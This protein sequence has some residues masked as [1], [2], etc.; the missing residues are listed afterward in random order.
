MSKPNDTEH[1]AEIIAALRD[2]AD[3]IESDPTIPTP[4]PGSIHVWS[5]LMRSEG[6]QSER[7]AA[8]HTFAEAHGA[9]VRIT[10]KDDRQAA[11]H[12]G[13]IELT[14]HAFGDE[15]PA[16]QPRVVTRADDAALITA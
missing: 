1:R 12:F 11:A 7:F 6:T 13:P 10:D 3:Q 4:D 5:F 14:V 9:T 2:F 16:P 15:Q 8:V